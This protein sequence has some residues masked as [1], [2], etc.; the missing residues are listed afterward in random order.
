MRKILVTQWEFGEDTKTNAVSFCPFRTRN[1]SLLCIILF[2]AILLVIGSAPAKAAPLYDA[3]RDFSTQSNPNSAWSYVYNDPENSIFVPVT[4]RVNLDP[5]SGVG[6]EG[7]L[8]DDGNYFL[9]RNPS[10][11]DV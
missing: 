6:F 10:S 3:E 9:L 2:S 5:N 4:N 7:W 1:H 8:F 11:N